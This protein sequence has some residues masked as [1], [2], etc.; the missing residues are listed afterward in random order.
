MDKFAVYQ[1]VRIVAPSNSEYISKIATIISPKMKRQVI[2]PITQEIYT[3]EVYRLDLM[4]GKNHLAAPEN[5]LIPLYDNES[6]TSV[7]WDHCG[8]SPKDKV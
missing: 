7:N 4:V 2:N 3:A 5:H 6:N 8:W 1:K